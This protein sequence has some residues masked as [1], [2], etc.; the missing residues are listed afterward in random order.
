MAAEIQKGTAVVHGMTNSG[1]AIT[2]AGFATFLLEG[3]KLAHKFRLKEVTDE[4]D[5]DA[6]LIATNANIEADIIF[7][8]S[9]ASKSAA[10]AICAFIAPLANVTIA[11]FSVSVC[12]GTW[13]YIGD[14]SVD[15]STG[16]AKIGLKLRKYTDGTQNTSLTTAVS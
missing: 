8:P 10:Q 16:V 14:E 1:S 13:N 15:L 12:N 6:T 4:N 7:T 11:N 9:G 5:Y 3:A 2:I